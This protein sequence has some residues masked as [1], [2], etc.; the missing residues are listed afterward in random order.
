MRD[1]SRRCAVSVSSNS[2]EPCG[3][4]IVCLSRGVGELGGIE[5]S[6]LKMIR[7]SCPS[8]AVSAV[9]GGE[10]PTLHDRHRTLRVALAA[11]GKRLGLHPVRRLE[12]GVYRLTMTIGH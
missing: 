6:S 10:D 5:G 2:R 4:D 8:S 9:A 1:G 12:A 3:K 7:R 11:T